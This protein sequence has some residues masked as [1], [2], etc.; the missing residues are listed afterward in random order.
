M[1][2]RELV[3]E[4]IVDTKENKTPN[5]HI[6]YDGWPYYGQALTLAYS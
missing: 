3:Q 5:Y 2:Y 6:K 4:T 1:A